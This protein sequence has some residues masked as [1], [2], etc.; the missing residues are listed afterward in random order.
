MRWFTFLGCFWMS[1]YA[2]S[3]PRLELSETAHSLPVVNQCLFL[4][5]SLSQF[6]SS[7][8][9]KSDFEQRFRPESSTVPNYG[10]TRATVWLKLNVQARAS[11]QWLLEV[12]NSRLNVVRCFLVQHHRLIGQ[13]TLGDSLAFEHYLLPDRNPV[14]MWSL[15]GAKP[16]TLYVQARTTEDL[17]LPLTFWQ[18]KAYYAHLSSKNLIWGIYFGF[19]VLIALYNFFLWATVREQIFIHYFFY[20]L[21][22]GLFQFSLYGFGFQY[23]WG[24]SPFNDRSHVAFIGLLTVFFTSFSIQFLSV[25]THFPRARTFF[26]NIAWLWIAGLWVS[27][28]FYDSYTNFVVIGAGGAMIGIQQFYSINLLLKGQKAAKLYLIATAMLSVS[29]IVVAL[30]NLGWLPADHQEYYLMAGSMLEITL[31]S[32]AL[33]DR[34][35]TAQREQERMLRV[36]NEISSDLHDDLAASL[37]SLTMYSELNRLRHQQKNPDIAE[38]FTKIS[39]R[40][41]EAMQLVRETVWEINPRNDQSEEWLDRLTRFAQDTLDAQQI[42]LVLHIA[43]EVRQLRLP[44]DERR[45]LFLFF[46][47]AINNIAKHAKAKEVRVEF[48]LEN[49]ELWIKIEDDG[50]GFDV[51]NQPLGNGLRNFETR[52][53]ALR[54][55]YQ[56]RSEIGKGTTLLLR[57]RVLPIHELC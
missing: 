5:D 49:V 36:R 20:V 42:E 55:T 10:Y 56:F 1:L 32:L 44:I 18:P 26:H 30:K 28:Y 4:M 52:A 25:F 47:E 40:S 35:R 19:I 45:H 31:F 41:R 17:K 7:S 54:A 46:K 3:Q 6:S 37:S 9:G 48:G 34:L 21:C 38:I 39:A 14:F 43:P 16:Y 11:G 27:V 24:N 23:V 2:C 15:E 57:F 8:F 12:D 50:V 29:L 13:Q 51:E 53:K 22:F 33:G